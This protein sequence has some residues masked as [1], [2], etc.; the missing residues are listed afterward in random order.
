MKLT[1][2][3]TE[4]VG[5]NRMKAVETKEAGGDPDEVVMPGLEDRHLVVNR[6]CLDEAKTLAGLRLVNEDDDLRIGAV[7]RKELLAAADDKSWQAFGDMHLAEDVDKPEG[8]AMRY[9]H[10]VI[11]R[12]RLF[13]KP[14]M[15]LAADGDP[16][17]KAAA[18]EVAKAAGI[19]DENGI[20]R[21]QRAA[22]GCPV[23][24]AG[25]GCP[26]NTAGRCAHLSDG[27]DCRI[28][29]GPC[30]LAGPA[31]PL[32]KAGE[33]CPLDQWSGCAQLDRDGGCRL[34]G[35]CALV[36]RNEGDEE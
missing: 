30:P 26:M 27:E 16:E 10:A 4:A 13:L 7:E 31:C 21:P 2:F 15:R 8:T 34:G 35:D 36:K 18:I 22:F 20:G 19:M 14:L 24:Q 5:V 3:E 9:K 25:R 29:G 28:A 11:S 33:G 32:M 1:K 6:R 17:V 12:G 23:M